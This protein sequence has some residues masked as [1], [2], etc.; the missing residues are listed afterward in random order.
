MAGSTLPPV[1]AVLQGD[2]SDLVAKVQA[3]KAAV[4]SLDGVTGTAQAELDITQLEASLAEAE[5]LVHSFSGTG[6]A[7][8]LPIEVSDATAIFELQGIHTTLND[9]ARM[10]TVD[11]PVQISGLGTALTEFIAASTAMR[12]AADSAGGGRGNGGLLAILGWGGGAFGFAAFGSV[13]SL[14]GL[15][16][17][18]A[19]TT[20]IGL[21][22]SLAGAIGG[23]GILATGVFG[24]MAVGMGSDMLVMSSTIADTK[25]LGTALTNIQTAQLTYGANSAQAAA[26]TQALNVQMELLGNTAGVQAE[27]GLAKA[28][29]AL[30]AYWDLTTSGARVAAVN[31]ITPFL[32]VIYTYIPL[33]AAAATR[34]F[35][36]LTVAFKPLIAWANGPATAIFKNL[37][38]LFAASIPVGVAALTNF[39]ELLA[40]IANW[41]APQS[42]GVMQSIE[43]FLAYLNSATGFAKLEGVMTTMVQM[44]KDWWA[45]L[46]QIAI[47]I[48]DLFS[49][50][51]GLGTTIVTTITAMLKQ[52]DVWLT[53]TSGK[54]SVHNLFTVHLQEIQA[55]L[56]ILPTLIGAF[57][58][59]YLDIAPPLTVIV[60]L[61]AKAVGWMLKI[62]IVGPLLAW[63]AAILILANRM[64]LLALYTATLAGVKNVITLFQALGAGGSLKQALSIAFG[65][66][67]TTAQFAGAVTEFSAAVARFSGASI[68]GGA[69]SGG[70]GLIGGLGSIGAGAGVGTGVGAG[71]VAAGASVVLAAV[72]GFLGL[73]AV[74]FQ[75]WT[76]K[77]K[78]P[79][80][81]IGSAIGI[82]S[83]ILNPFLSGAVWIATHLSIVVTAVKNFIGT[84]GTWFSQ[85]PGNIANLW[86]NVTSAIGSF[87]GTLGGWFSQLPGT[88]AHFFAGVIAAIGRFFTGV[89][90][91]FTQ[92]P[93]NIAKFLTGVISAIGSFFGSIANWWSHI[94]W[95]KL[96]QAV[97]TA[98]RNF[99]GAIGTW[100]SQLPGNIA[101]FMTT[102]FTAIGNFFGKVGTWFTQ[103]PGN[104]AK[105]MTTVFTDIGTFFGAVGA[106]FAALPKNIAKF[107]TTVFTDIGTFFGSVGTWFSNLFKGSGGFM[108][109]VFTDIGNFFSAIGTWFTNLPGALVKI[110][111]AV[112]TTI[113]KAITGI[114]TAIKNAL[115][116]IVSGIGSFFSGIWSGLTGHASGGFMAA[117]SWGTAGEGS[118][119]EIF[120]AM[121]GG[122]VQ[123]YSHGQSQG[124]TGGGGG[125]YAITNQVSIAMPAGVNLTPQIIAVAVQ[126]G[127]AQHDNELMRMIGVTPRIGAMS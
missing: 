54:A 59:L 46:K 58:Q 121:P 34:N 21:A 40:K 9:M 126:Q 111:A 20:M 22:G 43:N 117:G 63:A 4:E 113:G 49:Q 99:F 70:G 76:G 116:S 68:V 69:E 64:K 28:M 90:T 38:N 16:F 110:L 94:D 89:G 51:V 87:F 32:S 55:I 24:K 93:G 8:T 74:D 12:A 26:A 29:Q 41:A 118:A 2:I 84:I 7:L 62:P 123:I 25:L 3:A 127:L 39:V 72:L 57:G 17:E 82:F 15:G 14:A 92:L 5:A 60:T 100:F 27:L 56:A 101:K 119:T 45:L 48:Y 81:A 13:L 44:F 96:G 112:V 42:G 6:G 115:G 33:I 66:A 67:S 37:E 97:G 125:T 102:V 114:G 105:F 71:S 10:M 19:V 75:L 120:H 47:T 122:G 80:G 85:L 98:I 18:H 1:V 108:T 103:L 73:I 52:L 95:F 23:L 36:I 104:I 61:L 77:I 11:I 53:S 78:G 107:M 109:T 91:W 30:N 83:T 86:H 124:M 106:W 31:F 35:N 65:S 88:I 79:L 50:S